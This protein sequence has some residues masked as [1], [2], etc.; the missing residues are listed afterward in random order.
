MTDPTNGNG[1]WWKRTVGARASGIFQFK[2]AV[3]RR[4]QVLRR[5]VKR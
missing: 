2:T 3:L 4:S 5:P 1:S